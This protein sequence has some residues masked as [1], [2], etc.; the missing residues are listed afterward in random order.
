MLAPE[1]LERINFLANKAKT[2]GLS[3][4]EMDEQQALRQQYLKAFRQSFKSQMMGMKVVDPDGNDVTPQK[5]K[6]EQDRQRSE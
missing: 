5:L 6:E 4:Q 2:D 3:Q 1:Q